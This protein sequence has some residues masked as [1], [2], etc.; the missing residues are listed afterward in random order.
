MTECPLKTMR[1]LL[2]PHV[3]TK[4]TVIGLLMVLMWWPLDV[5]AAIDSGN[6]LDNALLKFQTAAAGWGPYILARAS[7][8]FWTLATISLVWTIGHLALRRAEIGEFLGEFLS[9]TL[10]TEFFW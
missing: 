9:F 2:E 8:L 4:H 6:L 7:W 10:M 5:H 1:V 3:R